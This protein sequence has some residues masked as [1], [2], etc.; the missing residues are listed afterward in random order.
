MKKNLLTLGLMIAGMTVFAQSPRLSLFEEFTGENCPPCASTN[1]GLNITLASPT[2]TTKV[3]AIKWQVPIPSAPT[4]TWSLWKTNQSEIQWRYGAS[5]AGYGYMSAWTSTT[6]PTSGINS[7]PQARIDGEHLWAI[8]GGGAA[9]DHAFYGSNALF[10]AASSYTS[11]FSISMNRAWNPTFT[12][13]TVTVNIQATA[14][15]TSTGALVYRLVMIERHINFATAPG[16]NGEKD[17]EDVAVKSYP[18]TQSGTVTTSMGTAM[19][20]AW[21][22]GQTQSFTI[23]CV[24]PSYIRDKS[25]VAFVGFIQDDGNKK[26]QQ[27]SLANIAGLLNDAKAISANIGAVVCS[28]TLIPTVT[29]KNIGSNAIT[30]FTVSPA[31]DAVAGP[32]V[33]WTGN[34]AAGASTTI[35]M[36]ML[37]TTAG[38]HTYS[39]NISGVSGGEFNVSNNKLSQGFICSPTYFAG[40]VVEPFTAV[41]FP[42]ANWTLV[43][44]NAGPTWSRNGAVGAYG[45]NTGAAKYDF[46]N[47]SANGDADDLY[48]PPS[49]LTAINAPVLSF[50][51]AYAPYTAA[52]NMEV[53]K[54]EVKVSTDCGANWATV[55]SQ[56]G[57]ALATS[58]NVTSAFVPNATQWK[59]VNV[60]LTSYS[61]APQVLVKFVATSDYGNNMYVD[62][63]NLAQ[64]NPTSIKNNVSSNVSFDL[65]PNPTNGET[66]LN[67]SSVL[68]GNA[69]VV[70]INT[71]G[72]VVFSKQVQLAVGVNTIQLDAKEF[73]SGLYNVMVESNNGSMVKKLTV[74]K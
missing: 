17:F 45:S 5:P 1:P 4:N 73:A 25:E 30:A 39:Y 13:V 24:L 18:T 34:L 38:S 48:L 10:A 32:N 7:A 43:N 66:T 42:P 15:Y 26:V 53:D 69:N 57:A 6:A 37:T 61:N 70:V 19:A 44:A 21:T 50:D 65:Y 64:A 40:P 49:D 12:A 33:V 67:I 2:N 3:V 36:N 41:T 72:Q 23:N 58:P 56:A 71:L 22:V 51:V 68:S 20:S 29:V 28:T 46:Y 9:N 59:T 54:L 35:P 31:L 27:A 16:T 62:N 52:P 47:N 11:P 8:P 14:N 63:I 74:T 60:A 55:F